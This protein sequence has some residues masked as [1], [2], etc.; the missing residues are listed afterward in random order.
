[1]KHCC[2]I[3][4]FKSLKYLYLLVFLWEWFKYIKTNKMFK[5][6]CSSCFAALVCAHELWLNLKSRWVCAQSV[7]AVITSFTTWNRFSF[8]TSGCLSASKL[9]IR[10]A[11]W[12]DPVLLPSVR[13]PSL[14]LSSSLPLTLTVNY[15]ISCHPTVCNHPAWYCNNRNNTT[16]WITWSEGGCLGEGGGGVKRCFLKARLP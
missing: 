10:A 14:R 7:A 9:H 16:G 3:P 11:G 1:M 8:F 13:S 6:W 5:K 15:G 4:F 2:T 12:R